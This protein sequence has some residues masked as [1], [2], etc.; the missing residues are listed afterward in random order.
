VARWVSASPERTL[1]ELFGCEGMY[2]EKSL[3]ISMIDP[4]MNEYARKS[5]NVHI[6][7]G[8]KVQE[9]QDDRN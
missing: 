9:M 1:W 5:K 6:Y 2:F 8:K 4:Y 7:T 3:S